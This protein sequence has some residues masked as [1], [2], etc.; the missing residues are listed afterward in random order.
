MKSSFIKSM[1]ISMSV[2]DN[3]HFKLGLFSIRLVSLRGKYLSSLK[4]SSR[5][6]LGQHDPITI[7]ESC[8]SSSLET[9]HRM[10]SSMQFLTMLCSRCLEALRLRIY[11]PFSRQKKSS[12]QST[13]FSTAASRRHLQYMRFSFTFLLDVDLPQQ[14]LLQKSCLTMQNTTLCS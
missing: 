1:S 13:I 7:M 9:A 6:S 4:S 14:Y 10:L 12:Q 5:L 8:Q 2:S 11:L 3:S